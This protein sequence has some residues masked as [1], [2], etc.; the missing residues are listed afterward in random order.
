MRITGLVYEPCSFVGHNTCTQEGLSALVSALTNN[1]MFY[2]T[3]AYFYSEV[4][5][6][7]GSA[8]PLINS[9]ATYASMLNSVIGAVSVSSSGGL[10]VKYTASSGVGTLSCGLT[11]NSSVAFDSPIVAVGLI[12]NG[13]P[14]ISSNFQNLN[15]KPLIPSE[16]PALFCYYNLQNG[17]L[18]KLAGDVLTLSWDVRF[19]I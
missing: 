4:F 2:L 16:G 7:T 13:D 14:G 3:N 15:I 12:V 9:T 5:S 10:T 8:D 17:S 6:T 19:T 1:S 18:S 11:L